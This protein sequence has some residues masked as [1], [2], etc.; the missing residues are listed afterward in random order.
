MPHFTRFNTPAPSRTAGAAPLA[1]VGAA[2]PIA[3]STPVCGGLPAWANATVVFHRPR[4]HPSG[5]SDKNREPSVVCRPLFFGWAPRIPRTSVLWV[6]H[7]GR[8]TAFRGPG[9]PSGH[10][11]WLPAFLPAYRAGHRP[12]FIPGRAVSAETF[13]SVWADRLFMRVLSER[14]HSAF[15]PTHQTSFA[16]ALPRKTVRI[17]SIHSE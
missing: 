6:R 9:Q 17:S 15:C 13:A 8:F 11:W 4:A 2:I 12:P 5:I 10:P 1:L 3:H 7:T 16:M 14:R